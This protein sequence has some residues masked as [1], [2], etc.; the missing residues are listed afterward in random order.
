MEVS[1]LVCLVHDGLLGLRETW[2]QG[3]PGST[4]E[5]ALDLGLICHGALI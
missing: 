3:V 2:H 1:E 5:A 4:G